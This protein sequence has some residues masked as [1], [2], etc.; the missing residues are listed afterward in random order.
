MVPRAPRLSARH[1]HLPWDSCPGKYALGDRLPNYEGQAPSNPAGARVRICPYLSF[2]A[3]HRDLVIC[4]WKERKAMTATNPKIKAE[5]MSRGIWA[6]FVRLREDEKR[7]HGGT[8]RTQ[9]VAALEQLAPDLVEL[10]RPRGRPR[11]AAPS[12]PLN[13]ENGAPPENTAAEP[14]PELP[15]SPADNKRSEKDEF[16]A[17]EVRMRRYGVKDRVPK[18]M[19]AGKTCT[20]SAAFMWAYSNLCFKDASPE[21]APSAVAWQMYVDM[22]TSPSLKADMLKSGLGAAMRKAETEGEVNGKFD[23]EGEYD[24]LAAIAKGGAE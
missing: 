13:A 20:I 15:Q 9:T 24:I 8:S 7:S 19:F 1:P 12:N 10:V 11:G 14:A 18:E 5:L 4:V 2:L 6:D 17:A 3:C 23:G 22:M 21:D 16:I